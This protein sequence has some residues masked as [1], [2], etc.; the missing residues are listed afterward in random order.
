MTSAYKNINKNKK[1]S[2]LMSVIYAAFYTFYD[3]RGIIPKKIEL[4]Y[5]QR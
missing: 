5:F 1:A 4:T 2:N 3:R